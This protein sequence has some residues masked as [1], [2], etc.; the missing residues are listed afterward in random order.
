VSANSSYKVDTTAPSVTTFTLS[1]VALKVGD[2]ATVTLVFSEAVASFANADITVARGTLA[3]MSSSDNVTWTGT[4]TPTA[5]TEDASN[6]LS[7]AT[8]YTDTA[9]NAGPAENTLNYAVDTLAPTVTFSMP[10]CSLW[11]SS[12]NTCTTATTFNPLHGAAG[13]GR[14]SNITITFS[15][16]VRKLDDSDLTNSNIDSLITLKRDNA[17]GADISFNATINSANTE[18]TIDPDSRLDSEGFVYVAIGATVEDSL[19]N[20]I[21]AS[22]ATFKT[23]KSCD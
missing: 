12:S 7:L 20:A 19:D 1:D 8:S 9:G 23:C 3:T 6:V 5:N 10:G 11:N 14:R 2:T 21:T 22:S 13:G 16:E 17:G 15:E 4:F 18:I